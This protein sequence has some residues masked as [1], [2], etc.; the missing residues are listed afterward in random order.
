MLFQLRN[1]K[2]RLHS[3]PSGE[4][5]ACQCHRAEMFFVSQF[6]KSVLTC[7][8]PKLGFWGGGEGWRRQD[9]FSS[10]D[11]GSLTTVKKNPP[12]P[13]LKDRA[14][15]VHHEAKGLSVQS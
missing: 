2:L 1:Q 15:E 13:P 9:W 14:G 6:E 4:D 7:E 5:E 11:W 3:P 8:L 12:P 10:F